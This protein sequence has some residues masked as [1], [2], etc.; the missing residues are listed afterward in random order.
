MP[1]ISVE[2]RAQL[3]MLAN[4]N[5]EKYADAANVAREVA[6]GRQARDATTAATTL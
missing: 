5:A 3:Q 6:I 4:G 2:E 1:D